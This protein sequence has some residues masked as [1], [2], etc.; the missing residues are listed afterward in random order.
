MSTGKLSNEQLELHVLNKFEK[1]R[2]DVIIRP[3][4]GE[5]CGA[6]R[7]G[8][9]ACVV[10]TDPITGATESI[11]KLA[12]NICVNDIASSGAEPVGIL[13]TLLCPEGTSI[14]DIETVLQDASKEAKLLSIEILGGHTEITDA[15]NRI[16]LTASGFGKTPIEKLIK[17]GGAKAGDYIYMTKGAGLE[18]T[19]IL[20]SEKGNELRGF[21]S[22]DEIELAKSYFDKISVLNEGKIG[23]EVGV[24]SMHDATEGG[25]LGAVYEMCQASELGCKIYDRKIIISD[26]TLKICSH[27][28]INPLKLISSG[29]ML[30]S[31]SEENASNLEKALLDNDILYSRIGLFTDVKDKLLIYGNEAE[32]MIFD[33]I[34]SPV[35][36]DLY[37]AL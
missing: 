28:N 24:S 26:V 37:L 1:I 18:G 17:T 27:F 5:D 30:I 7:V 31:V 21:L 16:V 22:N 23:R 34:E 14:E 6:F 2:E 9:Y 29:A 35:G 3:S 20:A 10:T 19:A 15:V 13:L 32:E 11:G 4:L 12:V 25:I 33:N 36:D 8:D